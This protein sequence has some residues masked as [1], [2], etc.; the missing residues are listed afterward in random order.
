MR[1]RGQNIGPREEERRRIRNIPPTSVEKVILFGIVSSVLGL[2][3]ACNTPSTSCFQP[4]TSPP[5]LVFPSPGA[6]A[7]PTNVGKLIFSYSSASNVV[8]VS[9]K[10]GGIVVEAT[11]V[12]ATAP[13]PSSLPTPAGTIYG[14][15]NV[16]ILSP[17]TTYAVVDTITVTGTC[18]YTSTDDMGSFTTQ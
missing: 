2:V 10:S 3:A 5:R 13:L 18:G 11:M 16:P 4:T 8:T 15:I 1:H 7:V 9:T 17:S 6:T 12:P 14:M